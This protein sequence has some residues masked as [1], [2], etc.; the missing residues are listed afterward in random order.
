MI[1]WQFCLVW[2]SAC[3]TTA[4]CQIADFNND[5]QVDL[6]DLTILCQQW[7]GQNE[8][9]ADIYPT[10][11][12]GIV[13]FKDFAQLANSWPKESDI[14]PGPAG[15]IFVRIPAGTFEMG[16]H[17]GDGRLDERPVHTAT[18]NSFRISKYQ[19]TNAQYV[20]YLNEAK[21]KDL[22]KLVNGSV[23]ASSDEANEQPYLDTYR[24]FSY[25]QIDEHYGAFMI[26]S[27]DGQ[28]M[29]DHP[30]VM[31]SWYGAKG[32][33][34]YYGYRLPTEAEWE[35][36]AR[37]GHHDPYYKYPWG[38]NYIDCS[39]A[40]YSLNPGQAC[41]P[42]L[43]SSYPYTTPVGRYPAN[44]YGLCDMAGNV[45]EWCSDWYESGYYQISPI[46]NPIGHPGGTQRVLRG[47]SWHCYASTC[48]VTF[49][50]QYVPDTRHFVT[51]IRP[52]LD[53]D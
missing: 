11:G 49:R 6:A 31:V 52:A 30:V 41:N 42:L 21:S 23:Y 13:N 34:D 40:N 38:S 24:K 53:A 35:Y 26:R 29:A 2:L 14:T 8:L 16:D 12:D 25:S 22:I 18:L 37:G 7:L 4:F 50:H 48:R 39:Y 1:R 44:W 32:F 9:S 28:S 45:W 5:N 10:N 43:L 47:A 33:C 15:M 51:G 17:Y 27:R 46:H 3:C 20:E 19:V 36:A